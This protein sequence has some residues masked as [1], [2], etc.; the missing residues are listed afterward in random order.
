MA[1]ALG[2]TSTINQFLIAL[3]F[4]VV[5]ISAFAVFTG[6]YLGFD[7][8]GWRLPGIQRVL[9]TPDLNGTW[10]GKFNSSFVEDSDDS[11]SNGEDEC[12]PR[13]EVQ[14]RWSMIEVIF[15]NPGSS[16]SE[17]TSATIRT[18]KSDPEI[19]FTYRNRKTGDELPETQRIHEGTN[20]LRLVTGEEGNA[21]LEGDY[22]T[23]E[24]R[25]NHGYMRFERKSKRRI[26]DF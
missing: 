1:I 16:R 13:L 18:D 5:G 17:S 7:Y 8:I 10:K 15:V 12:G 11:Q 9:A 23:D 26:L 2:I 19:L 6:F 21:V 25:N 3:N 22:Y 24:Q 14:Q 4:D 20:R